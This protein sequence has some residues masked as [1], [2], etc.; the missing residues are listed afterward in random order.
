MRRIGKLSDL[1]KSDM[2]SADDIYKK[3][4]TREKWLVFILSPAIFIACVVGFL[5]GALK[6]LRRSN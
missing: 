6:A 2:H 3:L 4:T 1:E 5:Y